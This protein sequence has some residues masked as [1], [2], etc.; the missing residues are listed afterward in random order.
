MLSSSNTAGC[1]EVDGLQE[2]NCSQA[3]I[4]L[5]ISQNLATKREP[6]PSI[7]CHAVF[8]KNVWVGCFF[9]NFQGYFGLKNGAR[10]AGFTPAPKKSSLR[11]KEPFANFQNQI[12]LAHW[13]QLCMVWPEL[14]SSWLLP[15]SLMLS[16]LWL[17]S[18]LLMAAGTSAGSAGAH[19]QWGLGA[20]RFEVGVKSGRFTSIWRHTWSSTPQRCC[21][22][23]K[24]LPGLQA[25]A[26]L[27]TAVHSQAPKTSFSLFPCVS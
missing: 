22:G 6:R 4:E 3:Q 14:T 26:A 24:H 23:D 13:H 19:L 9:F 16:I 17:G 10:T 25:P 7:P 21:Q 8:Q 11:S 5:T 27:S 20:P 18:H 12:Y 15:P 1:V 2:E